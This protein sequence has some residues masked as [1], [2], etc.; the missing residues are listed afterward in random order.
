MNISLSPTA[1][2]LWMISIKSGDDRFSDE[3]SFIELS[4][5][6][7]LPAG[8]G[9]LFKR[10]AFK[11]EISILHDLKI[12]IDKVLLLKKKTEKAKLFPIKREFKIVIRTRMNKKMVVCVLRSF[13]DW[14]RL[15]P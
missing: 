8:V 5:I 6:G 3:V 7:L 10:S 9:N 1:Q 12:I 14:I 4:Y 2:I 13:I 15:S 11:H